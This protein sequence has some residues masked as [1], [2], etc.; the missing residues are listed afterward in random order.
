LRSFAPLL[1]VGE[2][3][4]KISGGETMAEKTVKAKA[5]MDNVGE[6]GVKAG[7]MID[8]PESNL[9]QLKEAGLVEDAPKE[10]KPKGGTRKRKDDNKQEG[11]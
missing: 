7:D 9:E 6:A 2:P 3:T 10:N 5:L 8:V 11:E 4:K 1:S